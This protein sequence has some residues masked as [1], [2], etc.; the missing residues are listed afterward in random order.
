MFV[1]HCIFLGNVDSALGGSSSDLL[2]HG[3]P[4]MISVVFKTSLAKSQKTPNYAIFFYS[5][6]FGHI[7]VT[8]WFM[9]Y[10]K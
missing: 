1:V 8:Q 6:E 2:T 7:W 9:S 10:L 5:L 4:K 3:N